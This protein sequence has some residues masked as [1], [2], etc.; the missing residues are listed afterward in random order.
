[1]A[2]VARLTQAPLSW[3]PVLE[4]IVMG[5]QPT[6]AE[7]QRATGM[8]RIDLDEQINAMFEA[9]EI[10]SADGRNVDWTRWKLTE[11]GGQTLRFLRAEKNAVERRY[12]EEALF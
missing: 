1:M 7:L 8:S 5:G 3:L 2:P 10:R 11:V 4:A 6:A 12:T 9:G